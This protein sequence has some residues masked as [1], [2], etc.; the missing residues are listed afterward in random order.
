MGYPILGNFHVYPYMYT[1]PIVNHHN[2]QAGPS[3]LKKNPG[4]DDKNMKIKQWIAGCC[5]LS[6]IPGFHM[7]LCDILYIW[8]VVYLP[9][10][11]MWKSVWDDEIPNIW[12]NKIHVPN[13]QPDTLRSSNVA[14]EK[15]SVYR[16]IFLLNPCITGIFQ[17]A[18]SDHRNIPT[19]FRK[20]RYGGFL[21]QGNKK[22]AS[23]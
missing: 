11:K 15:S 9:L 4:M 12:K 23:V 18:T 8:L 19:F 2:T 5:T 1:H 3:S 21:K 16:W 14:M 20:R 17:P 22:K 6:R 10:W 7:W 13:H